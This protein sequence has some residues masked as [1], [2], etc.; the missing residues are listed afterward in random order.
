MLLYDFKDYRA[1]LVI[2][3]V[4][5][6]METMYVR[7]VTGDVVTVRNASKSSATYSSTVLK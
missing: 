5:G 6:F 7:M 4:D 2:S 3:L 1:T